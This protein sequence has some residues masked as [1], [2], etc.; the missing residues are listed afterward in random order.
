[1]HPRAVRYTQAQREALAAA[2]EQPGVTARDV[3]ELA[4]AG[5]LTHPSGA[6]L[7]PF[8]ATQSTVRSQARRERLRRQRDAANTRLAELPARDAL[9]RMRVR[10]ADA[11]E[12][13][14]RRIEIE[15]AQNPDR[16]VDAEQLRQLTRA[17]REFT[18]IPGPDERRPAPPGAKRDGVRQGGETRGGLAG[19]ILRASEEHEHRPVK[20]TATLS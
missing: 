11:I 19:R 4:A 3:V 10:L 5:A 7:D 12:A 6:M 20:L 18:W 16:S 13:E 9:E 1:M 17:V 8:I 15:Q 14:L 2:F